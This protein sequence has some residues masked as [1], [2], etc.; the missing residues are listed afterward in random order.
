MEKGLK[1]L[2]AFWSVR[3]HSTRT[4]TERQNT[5]AVWRHEIARGQIPRVSK[6]STVTERPNLAKVQVCTETE[7][8]EIR[9]KKKSIKKDQ[10]WP[11]NQCVNPFR[12]N[13]FCKILSGPS[14]RSGNHTAGNVL[15]KR[16]PFPFK[17]AISRRW[18]A[19]SH[20]KSA[21][22]SPNFQPARPRWQRH[23]AG[24]KRS[25]PN[26]VTKM[27]SVIAG[28][29][30]V[31][32]LFKKI[33]FLGFRVLQT[34][35]KGTERQNLNV[36][37]RHGITRGQIHCVSKTSTATERPNQAKV[38]AC[39]ETEKGKSEVKKKHQQRPKMTKKSVCEPL[40][41]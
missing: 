29:G 13:S 2:P 39:T 31:I 25:T 20:V 19:G 22:R 17:T 37:W 41:V 5:S 6:S 34:L 3:P 32:F 9:G 24:G 1:R 4:G 36:A 16:P 21:T 7:K 23:L 35:R 12:S 14:L 27:M 40:S 26:F 15:T 18:R 10:K 38:Q 33:I 30:D 11:K 8:E 28:D